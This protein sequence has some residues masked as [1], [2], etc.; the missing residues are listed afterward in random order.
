MNRILSLVAF[1]VLLVSCNPGQE[2]KKRTIDNKEKAIME[3]AKK[4]KIDSTGLKDLLV[5]YDDYVAAYPNDTNSANYLFKE[6]DF[7]RY[8]RQPVKSVHIYARI[9]NDYPQYI[10]RPYALFLQGFIYENEIRNL[11]SARVKYE[12]FLSTYP[13][14]PIAKDVR[15]TMSNMG[16]TPEQLIK[17]FE[18]REQADSLSKASVK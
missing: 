3:V 2:W 15:I 4:G 18:A 9:F 8:M 7:Y 10:K 16:K 13:N 11:D 14:H 12:Q 6:A 1:V 17:E 5:A